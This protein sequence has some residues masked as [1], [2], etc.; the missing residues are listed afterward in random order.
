MAVSAA[1]VALSSQGRVKTRDGVRRL[2]G[3]FLGWEPQVCSELPS[4]AVFCHWQRQ[5]VWGPEGYGAILLVNCDRDNLNSDKQ[6]NCDRH[7]HCLQG[8]GDAGG[9]L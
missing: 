5:W 2:A 3:R 4:P 1:G 8:E 6:D 9:S 7:V